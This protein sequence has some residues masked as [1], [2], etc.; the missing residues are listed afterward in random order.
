MWE[1]HA[2]VS[3]PRCGDIVLGITVL[4]PKTLGQTVLTNNKKSMNL[5]IDSVAS[6][7]AYGIRRSIVHQNKCPNSSG[8]SHNAYK[9]TTDTVQGTLRVFDMILIFYSTVYLISYSLPLSSKGAT[10]FSIKNRKQT[11][12][13]TPLQHFCRAIYIH[14]YKHPSSTSTS[15]HRS[16]VPST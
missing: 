2:A 12:S 8:R 1:L 3:R 14:T 9:K 6:H 16:L 10:H 7:V 13:P 15:A 11:V 4:C 5:S